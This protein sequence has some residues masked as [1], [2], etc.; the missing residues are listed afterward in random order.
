M[1]NQN[2]TSEFVQVGTLKTS[3][4][5]KEYINLNLGYDRDKKERT[6]DNLRKLHTVL[7]RFIK[8]PQD[9]GISLFYQD[10]RK[11]LDDAVKNGRMTE[12]KA[13]DIKSS[14]PKYIKKEVY[15]LID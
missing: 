13:E 5:G 7:T 8:D 9:K 14:I 10:P 1:S 6:D 4:S 12:D 3:K 15:L 2:E 11:K